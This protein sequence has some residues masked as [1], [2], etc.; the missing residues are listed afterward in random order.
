MGLEVPFELLELFF[1]TLSAY[2]G[3]KTAAEALTYLRLRGGV[4]AFP[5]LFALAFKYFGFLPSFILVVLFFLLK[6]N[7]LVL[8]LTASVFA[9]T[10]FLIGAIASTLTLGILGTALSVPGYEIHGTLEELLHRAVMR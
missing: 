2:W 5:F 7:G 4:L 8:S 10:L 6:G 9:F 1:L 3:L